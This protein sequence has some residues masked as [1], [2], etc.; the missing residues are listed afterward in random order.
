M[1]K[2][3]SFSLDF[4]SAV[5]SVISNLFPDAE[6][7][8]CNYHF[9]QS[10]WR[11][12]Q[13]VGLSVEYKTDSDIRNHIRK[14]ASLAFIDLAEQDDAW[15]TIMEDCPSNNKI[16]KFNDYFLEQWLDNPN[17]PR[18]MWNCS[19]VRDR[20]NNLVEGWNSQFNKL[21]NKK[22]PNFHL[23]V[24]TLRE[25]AARSILKIQEI[26][27][28]M[29]PKKRTKKYMDLNDRITNILLHYIEHKDLKKCL[30]RLATVNGL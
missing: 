29:P 9:N 30:N 18:E 3:T 12:V 15:L 17:V 1:W 21:V 20:T 11:K 27:V 23:L 4:E 2:P 6:L 5:M 26:N 13:D 14:C 24:K 22:Q 8:G 19:S 10:I 28:E 16:V 25:D 7:H